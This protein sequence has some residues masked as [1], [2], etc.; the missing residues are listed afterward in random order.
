MCIKR[1]RNA[2]SIGGNQYLPFPANAIALQNKE[3]S[4]PLQPPSK[5]FCPLLSTGSEAGL[6][7]SFIS[8]VFLQQFIQ[9]SR[10]VIM[11]MS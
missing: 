3:A 5:R 8:G 2:S 10:M 6:K 1:S 4:T 11:N 7:N 9:K